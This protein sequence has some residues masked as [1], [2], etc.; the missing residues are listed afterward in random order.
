MATVLGTALSYTDTSAVAGQVYY[1]KLKANNSYGNS[2]FSNE[3]YANLTGGTAG[4]PTA[5]QNLVATP[6]AGK[7]TLTWSAPSSDGGSA[8]TGYKVYRQQGSATPT[9]LTTVGASARTY[10][11]TSG[12]VGTAYSYWVV[13]TNVNGAGADSTPVTGTSQQQSG[14]GGGGLDTMVIIAI[15]AVVVVAGAGAGAFL[16]LRKRK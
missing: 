3:A 10:E 14:G 13:A 4:T 11:D 8:I 2:A 7:V 5:P 1:Y 12:T 16:M 15:V 9:L 6:S